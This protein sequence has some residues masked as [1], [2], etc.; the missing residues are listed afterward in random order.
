MV[1]AGMSASFCKSL[2]YANTQSEHRED[3]LHSRQITARDQPPFF[4]DQQ[5]CDWALVNPVGAIEI[6]GIVANLQH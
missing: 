4:A 2:I 1:K 6:K 5:I 3:F